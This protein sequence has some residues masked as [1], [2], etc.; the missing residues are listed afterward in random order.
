MTPLVIAG[1]GP[2]ALTL[3]CQL[4][5]KRPALR[6]RLRVFDPSGRWL[7]RWQDQLHRCA[8]PWLRSPSPHHPHPN[9]HALRRFAQEQQRSGELEGPYGLPHTNLFADFCRQVERDFRLEQQVE[10]AAVV[11]LQLGPSPRAP[12]T[13]G[14]S[15]GTLLQTRRLVVATGTGSPVLP[16]WVA[17]VGNSHPPQALQHSAS[18]D[19]HCCP[20]LAG[21]RLLIVGGGLTSGHLALG[22]LRLGA[23]VTLLCRRQLRQQPFDADPGWLGPKHLKAFAAEPC[24][25]RRHQ[26]V[27]AARNGGSVTPAVAAELHRAQRLGRLRIEE[28]CQVER[29]RWQGGAG[30]GGWTIHCQ[31]GGELQ[32]ERIWLATGQRLGVSE[33]PLLHQLQQQCPIPLVHDQPVLASDLSWPG[34]RVHVMGGLASLQLGPA[35]RNLFGGREAAL[36]I[37]AAIRRA[38]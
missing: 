7:Q 21:Q 5:Q 11:E 18:I 14:L 31:G 37:S 24:W 27:L 15:D 38:A 36:R 33:N 28:H 22:A 6:R 30:G 35:A 9:P 13:L 3:S 12:L 8:I 34:S 20:G 23:S 2:H 29:A 1:A 32:A 16:P 26:Q 19:L 10:A 4:L 17:A 25:Q